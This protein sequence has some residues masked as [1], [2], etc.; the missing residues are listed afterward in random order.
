MKLNSTVRAFG[1]VLLGAAASA[2][3]LQALNGATAATNA[4]VRLR[5]Y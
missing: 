3:T 4:S 5:I 2:I 1:L